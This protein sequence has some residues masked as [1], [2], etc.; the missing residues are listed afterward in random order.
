M[1]AS[2]LLAT[3]L[4][5]ETMTVRDALWQDIRL[6]PEL[7]RIQET[8]VFQKLGRIRQLGPVALVYPSAVHTRLEHSL[9]VYHL[10]NEIVLSLLSRQETDIFTL[11]GIHAFQCAALL[12][13]IGHFPY[14]HSLKELPLTH[15]EAL[16]SE[17]IMHEPVL[18]EAIKAAG[19]EPSLVADII[20]TSRPVQRQETLFYRNLLSGTLDPD[21]LDYLN[22]DAFFCGIPYGFQDAPYIIRRLSVADGK[23]ALAESAISSVEHVLFAKYLMY[24]TV[25]WHKE[26]RAATAMIKKAL[27]SALAE[28]S[29]DKEALY[30]L[31]DASFFRLQESVGCP[32]FTLLGDVRDGRLLSLA[33]ERPYSKDDPFDAKVSSLEGRMG[34][35]AL[36]FSKLSIQYPHL[37][38]WEVVIDIPEPVSFESDMPI[39]KEDGTLSC[40]ACEDTLFKGDLGEQFSRCL[41]MTRL[42]LPSSVDGKNLGNLLH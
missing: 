15:H 41:R 2:S 28:G 23:P 19:V 18:N 29:L 8:A 39:L 12:H 36:L 13:D 7:K 3:I 42:Y 34:Q 14:A 10:A 5:E 31:D 4:S 6:S 27:L 33:A 40:F 20:D 11:T 16:A 24:R 1:H 22:R 26:V 21:K 9:G 32:A 17:L 25:Y 38:P 30:G 35:E 37:K